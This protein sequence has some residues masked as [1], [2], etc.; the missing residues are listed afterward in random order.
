MIFSLI[1]KYCL[2]YVVLIQEIVFFPRYIEYMIGVLILIILC[3]NECPYKPSPLVKKYVNEYLDSINRYEI[4]G[5]ENKLINKLSEYTGINREYIYLVAGSEAFFVSLPWAMIK[6]KYKL[7]YSSPTFAPAIDDLRIWGIEVIDVPLTDNYLVDKE[8][9][10]RKAGSKSILYIVRPNNPTGNEIITCKEIEELTNYFRAIIIDE[11]YYEYSGLTCIDLVKKYKNIIILR[12]FSKAFCL[13]GARL[14]YVIADPDIYQEFFGVRRK[15]D[16]PVLSLLAGLGAI[17]DLE[18]M[19]WVVNETLKIKKWVVEKL[20]E[21]SNVYVIDTLT[22]FILVGKK[23]YDSE[24]L[25]RVLEENRI[26]VKKLSGRL[27]NYVRVSI[28]SFDEMKFF[29]EVL[30]RI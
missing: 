24:K 4:T 19:K 23:N 11:A 17:E 18:Y 21:L 2:D 27:K 26:L 3:R 29:I 15:Y 20:R 30:S 16:I 14:A 5:L 10:I 7:V 25:A 8:T 28:G 9:I 6:N 22:N 1:Y 12:T 13:A